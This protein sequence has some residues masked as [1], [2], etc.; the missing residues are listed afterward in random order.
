MTPGKYIH[1]TLTG[2]VIASRLHGY[3]ANEWDWIAEAVASYEGCTAG[4][5]EGVEADDNGPDRCIVKG[6]VVATIE[7][8]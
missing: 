5:V 8:S 3:G 6:Q 2:K 4:E 7:L 1:S